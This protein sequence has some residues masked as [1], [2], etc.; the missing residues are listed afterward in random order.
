MNVSDTMCDSHCTYEVP[1]METDF[2]ALIFYYL[3]LFFSSSI[4]IGV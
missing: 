2:I 4:P 3:P 1:E